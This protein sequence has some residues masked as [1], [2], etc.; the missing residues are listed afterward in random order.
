MRSTMWRSV[1][2]IA[3]LTMFA[4]G[5]AAAQTTYPNVKFGG[6]LQVQFY[7][8][9]NSGNSL[10][11]SL[12]GP[13]PES[14][15]YVRRARVSAKGNI[16]E[17]VSFDI[18]PQYQT[19]G[20]GVT[21]EEAYLDVAF[22]KPE[23]KSAFVLRAGQFKRYFGRY[24]Q[25]STTNLPSIERGAGRGLIP[26]ASNDIAVLSGYMSLDIGAGLMFTGL[27]KKLLIEGA[28]MNGRGQNLMDNNNGKSFY[29]R[30]TYNITPKLGLG[31]SYAAHESLRGAGTPQVD[32]S[33]TNNGYGLDGQWGAAGAPGLYVVFDY[34]AGETLLDSANKLY[35]ISLVSAYNIRMKSPTS[36]LYAV[37]PAFRYDFSEPNNNATNDQSTLITAGV[38]LYLSSK[39]Q[40]RL[41]Y[42]NQSFEDPSLKTI[43]GVLTALTMNF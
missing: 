9:N 6:M 33:A 11:N 28:I 8:Y 3:G 41:M 16:S 13:F 17:A 21:V 2:A 22:T 12:P 30:A 24:E 37:E 29:A 4:A 1:L 27:Q 18:E 35:G 42:Q 23:A 31:A 26:A 5:G 19:N 38:N 14:E 43:S 25:S 32:S 36:F 15:F 10:Y 39:A 40:F 7:D 20:A 34:D